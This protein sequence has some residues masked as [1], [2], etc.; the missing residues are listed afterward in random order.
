MIKTYLAFA[1]CFLIGSSF[2]VG[3]H[4]SKEYHNIK[5]VEDRGFTIGAGVLTREYI[6]QPV[7]VFETIEEAKGQVLKNMCEAR[8][9]PEYGD[10]DYD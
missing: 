10:R 7:P 6:C 9:E 1:G 2:A 3:F 8:Y 4:Y 5:A